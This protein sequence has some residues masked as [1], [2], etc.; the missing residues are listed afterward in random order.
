[1]KKK[2]RIIPKT[3]SDDPYIRKLQEYFVHTQLIAKG[4]IQYHRRPLFVPVVSRKE[5]LV[6][7]IFGR[8]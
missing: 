3:R 6:D 2:P 1:M 7:E 8:N 4:A 5:S